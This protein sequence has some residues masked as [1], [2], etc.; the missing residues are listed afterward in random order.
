MPS[1][2]TASSRSVRAE[3]RSRTEDNNDDAVYDDDVDDD[4]QC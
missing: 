1:T 2:G 3:A 4:D